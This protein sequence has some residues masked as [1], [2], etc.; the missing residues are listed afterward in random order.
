MKVP[1]IA[2]R[3]TK[4][5][6]FADVTRAVAASLPYY[7]R[8]GDGY[9]HCAREVTLHYDRRSGA[10]THTSVAFWCGGHGFLPPPG[11]PMRLGRGGRK[12]AMMVAEPSP[13]RVV[14][15]TCAGR[16]IGSGQHGIAKV[17]ENFVKYRPRDPFIPSRRRIEQE[18][19]R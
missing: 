19:V 11:Q 12:P 17:G 7:Q 4:R 16:G 14:C 1:L 18:I 15:A 9:V 8:E 3:L 13:G 10:L 5:A 2:C 6:D